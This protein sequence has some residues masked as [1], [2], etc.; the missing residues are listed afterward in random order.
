MPCLDAASPDVR[1]AV[2]ANPV[3]HRIGKALQEGRFT[4]T[5]AHDKTL[6]RQNWELQ[7]ACALTERIAPDADSGEF[8]RGLRKPVQDAL[9][10]ARKTVGV[11]QEAVDEL[12]A[13]I[14][15]A[16]TE[17]DVRVKLTREFSDAPFFESK[18]RFGGH[19]RFSRGDL[20]RP[21]EAAIKQRVEGLDRSDLAPTDLERVVARA[22]VVSDGT[23]N[24]AT[25]WRMVKA[26]KYGTVPAAEDIRAGQKALL[27]DLVEPRENDTDSAK[28]SLAQ[29][30]YRCFKVVETLQICGGRGPHL[31]ALGSETARS[32]VTA[33]FRALHDI[34]VAG[35]APWAILHRI[36]ASTLGDRNSNGGRRAGRT[37][38]A[39]VSRFPTREN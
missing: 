5:S 33:N 17:A 39:E 2:Q 3:L 12:A 37:D 19:P 29:R 4:I 35:P 22:A 36:V 25:A 31:K 8:H 27:A 9:A 1:A 34:S 24:A 6:Q 16:R 10:A 13:E 38:P 11:S 21:Y 7:L 28:D 14:A 23:R 30:I 15:R 32:Q 18:A 20:L 26:L